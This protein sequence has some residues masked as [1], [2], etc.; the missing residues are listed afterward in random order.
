MQHRC[1]TPLWLNFFFLP[2][3]HLWL[4]L[5][6]VCTLRSM[7]DCGVC[8][9]VNGPL[10]PHQSLAWLIR[11]WRASPPLRSTPAHSLSTSA[12]WYQCTAERRGKSK[13]SFRGFKTKKAQRLSPAVQMTH[14][15]AS[16]G[17]CRNTPREHKREESLHCTSLEHTFNNHCIRTNVWR[18][19]IWCTHVSLH[20]NKP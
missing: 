12:R 5:R 18:E 7:A 13:E 8:E 9:Q 11:Q 20:L 15:Q 3:P 16:C 4:A 19:S 1:V 14:L 10:T 17:L 2:H 6:W